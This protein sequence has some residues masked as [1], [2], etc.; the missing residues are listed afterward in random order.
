M[1]MYAK[2]SIFGL[3]LRHTDFGKKYKKRF[4]WQCTCYTVFLEHAVAVIVTYFIVKMHCQSQNQL[5]SI[6]LSGV[7]ELVVVTVTNGCHGASQF[8]HI[9]Y[10]LR[11]Q[12]SNLYSLMS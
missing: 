9:K 7:T 12:R 4:S 11:Q 8:S 5:S 3:M 6:Y 1:Y 2:L 10:Q